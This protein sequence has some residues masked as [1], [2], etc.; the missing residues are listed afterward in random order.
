MF[1]LVL[2]FGFSEAPASER[3]GTIGVHP[4][5]QDARSK[6]RIA[7]YKGAVACRTARVVIRYTLV[8]RASASGLASPPGWICARGAPSQI[9]TPTGVSC[10]A[11]RKPL[12][13]VEG[14]LSR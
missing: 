8:H 11:R 13:I 3:C 7:V 4:Y 1:A 10:T 14:V 2:A 5:G 12:R 6:V 9:H